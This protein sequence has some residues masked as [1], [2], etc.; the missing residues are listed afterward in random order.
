MGLILRLCSRDSARELTRTGSQ[1]PM[2]NF[3]GGC[4]PFV[5][6]SHYLKSK[7]YELKLNKLCLKVDKYL[8]LVTSCFTI[9]C[10]L[11]IVDDL[12]YLY[13]AKADDGELMLISS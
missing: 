9:I 3:Q 11:E 8:T 13:G 4:E 10:A 1:E 7:L 6:H 2:L 12:L 5:K